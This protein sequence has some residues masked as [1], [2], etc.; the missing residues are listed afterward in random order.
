[1]H[2]PP[3]VEPFPLR[4]SDEI[5]K[6]AQRAK[7]VGAERFGIVASGMAVPH[8]E[9]NRIADAVNMIRERIGINTCASLGV[10]NR[11]DLDILK[12]AGLSRY[13]HNIETSKRYFPGICTTHKYEDRINTI[14]AA[15]EAGLEICSG[16]IIGIGENWQD[17]IDMAFQLSELDV[18]AVPV[19]ILVPIKG[20]P[21][22][23]IEPVSCVDVI[24]TIAIFRLILHD[25]IIKI[26]AGRESI[27]KDFQALAF[28]SG[29]NG[30][31]VDGYL[32]LKGRDIKE[33]RRFIEEI[34]KMWEQ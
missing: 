3:I 15:L 14:K 13:H 24:R 33:D 32:T 30:M 26:A 6:A 5:L 34:K 25:R 22:D 21:L 8:D 10:L 28:M 31:F 9:V 29:A 1:M 19:N 16:G 17:R 20:T 12:K 11:K 23:N 7:D 2:N 18:A 4:N 27:M